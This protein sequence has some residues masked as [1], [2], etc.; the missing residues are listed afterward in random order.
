MVQ[1]RHNVLKK[2]TTPAIVLVAESALEQGH[3]GLNGMTWPVP[4]SAATQCLEIQFLEQQ[5]FVNVNVHF[6]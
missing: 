4:S 5:K 6:A 1:Q 2:G 3:H